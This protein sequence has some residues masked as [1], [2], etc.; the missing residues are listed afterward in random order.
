MA[1]GKKH[2]AEQIMN[3]LRQVGIGVANGK[4]S[5]QACREAEIVEQT[6]Y[7]W[8]RGYGGLKVGQAGQLNELEQES[9]ELK[10]LVVNLSLES[11]SDG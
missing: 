7:R 5:P 8:R 10:R 1:R 2:T 3:L 11:W 4:T 6:Y 9:A